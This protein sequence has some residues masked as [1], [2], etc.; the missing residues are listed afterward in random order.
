MSDPE[1]KKNSKNIIKYVNKI[2]MEIR[3]Y[4]KL[5]IKR[6][7]VDFNSYDYLKESEKYLKKIF[8]CDIEIFKENDDNIYD[9]KEKSRFAVPLRPAIYIE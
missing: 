5:D 6:Y 8:K 9:P 2:Q 1:M 4:N 3:K 7:M